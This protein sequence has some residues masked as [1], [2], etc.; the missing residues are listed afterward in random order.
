MWPKIAAQ[1]EAPRVADTKSDLLPRVSKKRRPEGKFLA[2]VTK[3][4][5]RAVQG[6]CAR[7]FVQKSGS[8][9]GRLEPKFSLSLPSLRCFGGASLIRWL[10][11]LGV[12]LQLV[13][14]A[15]PPEP[16]LFWGAFLCL[17]FAS[18]FLESPPP[19]SH[20]SKGICA[21]SN[22]TIN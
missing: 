18:F 5:N 10:D 2:W 16:A 8:I 7:K 13:F 6:S 12:F 1:K 17:F 11:D 20:R 9:F 21:K 22:Q 4:Q 14:S 3:R 19:K 15:L